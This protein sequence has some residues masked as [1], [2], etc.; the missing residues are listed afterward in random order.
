MRWA[1]IVAVVSCVAIGIIIA[2]VLKRAEPILKGRIEETIAART[3]GRVNLDSLHVS[4]LRGLQISGDGLRIYS[5]VADNS[6]VRPLIA[7][8]HFS[9][10]S[11]VIG[12]FFKPMHVHAVAVTGLQI[13]IPPH[14]Q[15]QP[16]SSR[17]KGKIK[18]AVDEILCQDSRLV[19]EAS[20]PDKDPRIFE[21]QRIELHDFGSSR[22]WQYKAVL[23][24]PFH[25]VKFIQLD[26][27]DRS[28]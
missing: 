5:G 15:Q 18:I 21:L 17:P 28:K 26:R 13:E 11:G 27:S 20:R 2:I 4:I 12:L 22:P 9:F 24:T 16:Q 19:I 7:V 23:K 8:A 3:G 10:R 1:V 6:Q 25:A 14:N